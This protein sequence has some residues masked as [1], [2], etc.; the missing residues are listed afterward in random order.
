VNAG[1]SILPDE[2]PEQVS[3]LIDFVRADAVSQMSYPPRPVL[4]VQGEM[5]YGATGVSLVPV[6]YIS[7]PQYWAIQVVGTFEAGPHVS[8]PIAAQPYSVQL[9]LAACTGTEGVEVIGANSTEKIEVPTSST[10]G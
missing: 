10:G 6:V 7:Q 8:Q 5:P 1:E 4:V 3:R 2:A 9:D